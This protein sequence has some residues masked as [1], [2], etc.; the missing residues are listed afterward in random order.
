MKAEILSEKYILALRETARVGK[1]VTHYGAR[2]LADSHEALRAEVERLRAI[3]RVH[4][5][6][7]T[8]YHRC[9]D[10]T[11]RHRALDTEWK[12]TDAKTSQ[13]R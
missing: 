13:A 10:M 5:R 7:V 6:H 3:I 11:C 9:D 12:A 2:L 1:G 8:K 4:G